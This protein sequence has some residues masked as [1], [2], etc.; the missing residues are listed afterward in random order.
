[1]TCKRCGSAIKVVTKHGYRI[2]YCSRLKPDTSPLF[3]LGHH[4]EKVR[5][6]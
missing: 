3:T 1:M 4:Y 2:E 5:I 6:K